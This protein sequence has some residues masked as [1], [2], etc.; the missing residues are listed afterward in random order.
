MSGKIVEGYWDCTYCGT[1][2]ISGLKK[3][4]PTCG[5][6]VGKN[7]KYYLKPE[8]KN[9][10]DSETAKDYGN[11]AD[12][13]CAYCGS[14]NRYNNDVCKNCGSQKADALEDYFGNSF[15]DEHHTDNTSYQDKIRDPDLSSPP[16]K[17]EESSDNFYQYDNT[18]STKISENHEDKKYVITNILNNVTMKKALIGAG[19]L[20]AIIAI[21]VLLVSIFTPK[22]YNAYITNKSWKRSITI[23][24]LR[25]FNESDWYVPAGARV[26]YYQDEIRS[27]DHVVDHYETKS[28]QV[29]KQVFSHYEY[30][31]VD[32]G[33][34]TFKEVPRAVYKTEYETVYEEEPVYVDVPVYDTRY[35][36]EIDRWC[37]AR[38]E[39]TSGDADSSPYWAEFELDNNERES[40]RKETYTI[41]FETSKKDFS[42]NV[43]FSEW[44][45]YKIGNEVKITV[46]AGVVTEI[47]PYSN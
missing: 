10:L 5:N 8:K 40:G 11:G 43:N 33:D 29:P 4:C 12:W 41:N 35:Y 46:V 37:Y 47:E 31:Y 9:Y 44:S 18:D 20:L 2:G 45:D 15:N 26:Y 27:Y 22:E 17:E 3:T 13:V 23:Q 6:P 16:C 21:I 7:V 39:T 25:T 14:Y 34:G 42:K 24:E 36:Y 32:N 1:K 28:Y 38:N 19:G 30:D